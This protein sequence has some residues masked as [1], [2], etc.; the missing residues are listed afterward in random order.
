MAKSCPKVAKSKVQRVF[1]MLEDVTGQLQVPEAS[2]YILPAGRATMTQ[3]PTFSD[4]EELSASLNVTEQFQ[5][6]VPA[7]SGSIPLFGRLDASYGKPEGDA[8]LTALMGDYN[9]PAKIS[10][11]V[12]QAVDADA[13]EIK[14]GTILNNNL[15]DGNI[16][17]GKMPPRGVIQCGA[18]KI[19]YQQVKQENGEVILAD[20]KRGYANTAKAAIEAD[21]AINML[22]RVWTQSVCRP[23]FSVYIL[24]DDKLCLFMSGCSVTKL[25]VRLQRENGQMF[26][27]EFQG[28][29][30]GWCGV[31]ELAQDCSGT[32][33]KLTE[34]GA[35]AFAVGGYVRN[36]TLGELD[37]GYRITAVDDANDTITLAAA[38]A[39]W[40]AGHVIRPWLPKAAAAGTVLESRFANVQV[41]G[42]TGH[43]TDGGLEIQTPVN[44][45]LNIGDE[46]V[47]EGMDGKR[48]ISLERSIALRE[49][50]CVEFGRGYKGYE[51]PVSV[52]CGKYPGQVLC[53]YMPRVKFGSPE[54]NESES[55]LTLRQNG[56]ALGIEGEDAL[57]VIQE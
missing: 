49:K 31:G 29:Q 24:E 44:H 42:V 9:D 43:M 32:T 41:A 35:D 8:L 23:T 37:K 57:F 30:M 46:F 21:A 20:C 2:G 26:T 15:I 18:E 25:S 51:L 40:L 14:I 16:L 54:L 28:R 4:S 27:F 3:T 38:P 5:N 13:A 22:S 17:A 12:L 47:G 50:D 1:V 7:G 53:F 11:K 10:C 56:A 19:L 33:V 6:A 52:F 45:L 36:S 55:W 34:G 39:G 48:S